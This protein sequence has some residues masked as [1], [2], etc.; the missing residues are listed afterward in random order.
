[1]TNVEKVPKFNEKKNE[2]AMRSAKANLYLAMKLLVPTMLASFKDSLPANEQVELDL[3]KPYELVKNM[4][5][6]KNHHTMNLLIVMMAENDLML[7][8]VES[9]KNKECPMD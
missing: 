3:N 4:C 5:K 9:V 1:M 7:M 2:F 8:M 6:A